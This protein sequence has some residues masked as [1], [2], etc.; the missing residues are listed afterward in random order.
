VV[1]KPGKVQIVRLDAASKAWSSF[2][3]LDL[4]TQ[5]LTSDSSAY[6]PVSGIEY[7]EHDDS[8]ILSL[9]DGSF[10]VITHLSTTPQV[11]DPATCEGLS[12]E[13]LSL[14]ARTA[15]VKIESREARPLAAITRHDANRTS[16]MTSY[17]GGRTFA[18]LHE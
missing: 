14:Q 11:T 7:I 10:H 16:G 3:A 12:S 17:D 13:A 18:W 5:D 6:Y 1:C 8:L 4:E 15:F 2:C 9:Y